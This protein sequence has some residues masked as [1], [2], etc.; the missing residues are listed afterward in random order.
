VI[1]GKDGKIDRLLLVN[2]VRMSI[3]P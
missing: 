1:T 3:A 2:V